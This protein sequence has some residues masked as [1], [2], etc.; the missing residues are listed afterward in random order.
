MC[1]TLQT[2]KVSAADQLNWDT[3]SAT[4]SITLRAGRSYQ[5]TNTSTNTISI[6]SNSSS[7]RRFDYVKYDAKGEIEI[8]RDNTYFGHTYYNAYPDNRFPTRTPST[9]VP[10][11]VL[12]ITVGTEDI[13]LTVPSE[14][15]NG[16]RI[17]E[18]SMPALYH[19][20][21]A[22]GKTYEITN[23]STHVISLRHNSNRENGFDYVRYESDGKVSHSKDKTYFGHSYYNDYPDNRF[24][25]TTSPS[26]Q[27]RERYV[28]T[29][30][31]ANIISC[32]TPYEWAVYFGG[33]SGYKSTSELP[34]SSIPNEIKPHSCENGHTYKSASGDKCTACGHTYIPTYT[35]INDAFY[36]IKDD[37]LVY[38]NSYFESG[39]IKTL[40]KD[41]FVYVTQSFKNSVGELW[42]TTY[43]NRYI[44]SGDIALVSSVRVNISGSAC[45]NTHSY[46][47][48]DGDVCVVCGERFR[49]V[50]APFEK[51][52]YANQA[53]VPVRLAPYARSGYVVKNMEK[54]EEIKLV[55]QLYNSINKLWYETDSG[56]YVYSEHLTPTAPIKGGLV[57]FNKS[58]MTNK[59]I[60]K[61]IYNGYDYL[62]LGKYD[63]K[64]IYA[65]EIECTDAKY[66]VNGGNVACTVTAE[67]TAL[68]IFHEKNIKPTS[69]SW[70]GYAEWNYSK[71][72]TEGFKKITKNAPESEWLSLAYEHVTKGS[73][74][75]MWV[76]RP[77][78][79]DHVVTAIGIREGA[80]PNDLKV[81]DFLIADSGDID[82]TGLRGLV[83]NL[84]DYLDSN[85]GSKLANEFRFWTPNP[86][87]SPPAA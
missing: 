23:S 12:R 2:F 56:H 66:Y 53:N 15:A 55:R 20:E 24:P 67:A 41:D 4:S 10:Q 9:L 80:N 82:K 19:F 27:P 33:E 3:T 63:K 70:P 46:R 85:S 5:I 74:V 29:V 16:T 76:I 50:Y 36:S 86:D 83:R 21:F 6:S 62:V 64:Y 84:K 51:N 57:S 45:E 7:S 8:W 58:E 65:Q 42:Y 72:I 31:S 75:I 87:K 81:Y 77:N 13:K 78:D 25:K 38:S 44:Y 54:D 68:S 28:I 47:S 22:A 26:L 1:V 43:E 32:S 48:A 49:P 79:P 14:Q 11:G 30:N 37:V 52:M 59:S 73:P 39:V 34:P 40:R 17:T 61:S 69:L 60:N 71:D 18:S 35:A